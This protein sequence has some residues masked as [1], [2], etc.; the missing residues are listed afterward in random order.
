[1]E[2]EFYATLQGLKKCSRKENKRKAEKLYQ[3][4]AHTSKER[5]ISLV[6]GCKAF[7]NNVF[8]EL[9]QDVC[10]SCFI[11]LS[12][13]KPPLQPIGGLTLGNRINDTVYLD[14]KGCGHN[15]YWI[16]HLIDTSTRYS[17]VRLIKTKRSE[18]IIRNIFLM[19]ISYFG[20]PKYFLNDNG[21]EFNNER[22][23]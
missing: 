20:H 1:M 16:L 15:Q 9:I 12:F 7:N 22:Y 21:G 23:W 8:L 19:W 6:R 10:D 13:W 11:C 4:F 5:L 3:P 17:A 14:L 2:I 18:K